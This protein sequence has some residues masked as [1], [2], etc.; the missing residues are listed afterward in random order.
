[1]QL[2][3]ARAGLLRYS[4]IDAR[5]GAIS[6]HR[7]V[8]AATRARLAREGREQ[9]WA[10]AA[11]NLVNDA[12]PF[13]S[14]KVETWSASA[15]LLPHA[16]AAAGHSESLGAAVETASR[17]LNAAHSRLVHEALVGP[18]GLRPA[19]AA[20]RSR[21]GLRFLGSYLRGSPDWWNNVSA[22]L[23]EQQFRRF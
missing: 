14:D 1:L 3:R 10:E 7:L 4:L 6:V 20:R 16:L 2:D 18:L 15:R 23:K 11:V 17:L 8:Q 9:V 12:F 19:P 22:G 13:E 21:N 5:S